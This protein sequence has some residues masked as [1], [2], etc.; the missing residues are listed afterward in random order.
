M[1]ETVGSGVGRGLAPYLVLAAVGIGI[2]LMRDK[3]AAWFT[4]KIPGAGVVAAVKNTVGAGVEAYESWFDKYQAAFEPAA[5][6][7]TTPLPEGFGDP[8]QNIQG[9]F[10]WQVIPGGFGTAAETLSG[11][12]VEAI[13]PESLPSDS[14]P[15]DHSQDSYAAVYAWAQKFNI[16]PVRN[17]FDYTKGNFGMVINNDSWSIQTLGLDGKT[18]RNIMSSGGGITAVWSNPDF[19]NWLDTMGVQYL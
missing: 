5:P 18:P 19:R 10:N 1:A 17:E 14:Y 11:G 8:T 2:Y 7:I 9:Q 6:L 16:N 4:S 13:Q 15:V 12:S 3:I